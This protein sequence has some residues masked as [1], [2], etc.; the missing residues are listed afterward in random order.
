MFKAWDLGGD[1]L[2]WFE[3]FPYLMRRWQVFLLF[4][5]VQEDVK[6]GSQNWNG[7]K[8]MID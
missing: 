1:E 2:Q 7:Q 5:Q 8:T 6:E 4:Q 3:E